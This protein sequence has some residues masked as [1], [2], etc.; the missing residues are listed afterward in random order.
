MSD[1][2]PPKR[3]KAGC[4]L[5]VALGL[6]VLGGLITATAT[7][8]TRLADGERLLG[9][10]FELGPLP[11]GFEVAGA[12][13]EMRGEE[14]VL[15]TRPDAPEEAQKAEP[16]KPPP[17]DAKGGEHHP[18][19][20]PIDWSAIPSGPEDTPPLEVA[21]VGYPDTL[22]ASVLDRLFGLQTH[23]EGDEE[24]EVEITDVGPEGG[25]VVMDRGRTDWGPYAAT[26]VCERELEYGKTF[27][28]VV[29][30]NLSLPGRA[31]VVFVRWPRGFPASMARVTEV[32]HALG[33]PAEETA[34]QG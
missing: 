13:V 16:P 24:P 28:D 14:V 7:Q 15:L 33:P 11:F 9:E 8:R 23:D 25:K 5:G 27:R 30:V 22:A 21:V 10:W 18:A 34:P 2:D 32:L 1:P 4:A 26:Y 20:D 19:P 12:T 17:E 3:E 29:R 31:R 6:L